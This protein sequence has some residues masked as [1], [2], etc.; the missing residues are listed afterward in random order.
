[1]QEKKGRW[2]VRSSRLTRFVARYVTG[3]MADCLCFGDPDHHHDERRGHTNY[4]FRP[5]QLFAV[6]WWRRYSEDRQHRA[7]AVVEA[8][9]AGKSGHVL[10]SIDCAVAVHAIVDQH[11]PAGQDG[12]VDQFIDL[13]QELKHRR[14]NPATMPASYWTET[15]QRI[16]LCQ[17]PIDLIANVTSECE[18]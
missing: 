12:A 2:R 3:S 15:A 8:L 11:G 4:H 13:V 17:K 5:G 16:L 1:M 10:P 6:V 7:L 18:V 14:Q 9:A